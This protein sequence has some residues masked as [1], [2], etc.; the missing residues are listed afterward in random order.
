MNKMEYYSGIKTVKYLLIKQHGWILRSIML[1]EKPAS[2]ASICIAFWKRELHGQQ[3]HQWLPEMG[4]GVGYK[5]AQGNFEEQ[6]NSLLECA[7]DYVI[8]FDKTQNYSFTLL[9]F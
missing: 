7:G 1:S 4:M 8:V 9:S 6:W 3:T 5:G 2:K